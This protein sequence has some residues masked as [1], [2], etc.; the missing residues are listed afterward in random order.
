MPVPALA[1]SVEAWKPQPP[2]NESHG[3]MGAMAAPHAAH[4]ID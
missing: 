3:F 1:V 2:Q 4:A